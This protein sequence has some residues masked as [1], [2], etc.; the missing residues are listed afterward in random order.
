[1][2]RSG[3]KIAGTNI[4][5]RGVNL[6]VWVALAVATVLYWFDKWIIDGLGVNGSSTLARIMSYLVRLFEWGS[7]QWYAVVMVGG[8]LGFC[9]YHVW[10]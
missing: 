1:M 2:V 3:T 10:K 5:G 4:I 8:L 9:V 7:V 6:V